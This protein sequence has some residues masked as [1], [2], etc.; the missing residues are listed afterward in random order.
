MTQIVVS[1]T[2]VDVFVRWQDRDV[3]AVAVIVGTS[4]VLLSK[5]RG[6]SCLTHVGRERAA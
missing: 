2:L 5:L 3:I 6:S 4:L 1:S